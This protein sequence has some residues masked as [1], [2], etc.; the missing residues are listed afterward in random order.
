MDKRFVGQLEQGKFVIDI[1][2]IK[3]E[4]G[5]IADA[6]RQATGFINRIPPFV[7]QDYGK[8]PQIRFPETAAAVAAPAGQG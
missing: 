8:V 4:P 2:G 6:W 5:P 1:T 7:W 3:F